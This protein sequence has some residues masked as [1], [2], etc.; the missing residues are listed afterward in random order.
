VDERVDTRDQDASAV[1][2]C[3][4]VF[5]QNFTGLQIYITKVVV[6]ELLKKRVTISLFYFLNYKPF[7][8]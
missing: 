8:L 6:N 2:C 7:K 5:Q 1:H 3:S 4:R